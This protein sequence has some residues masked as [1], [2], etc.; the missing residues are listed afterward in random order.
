MTCNNIKR[1]QEKLGSKRAPFLFLVRTIVYIAIAVVVH[2]VRSS[3]LENLPAAVQAMQQT[4]VSIVHPENPRLTTLEVP[5]QLFAYTDAPIYAQTSGY[6]KSW[7]F[8]IGAKV[9][10]NDILAEIDTPEVDRR[11]LRPRPN[12]R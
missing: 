11:L 10:A 1:A 2:Q 12:S 3:Q 5:G 6:L 7:S 9:K 4:T 8:D